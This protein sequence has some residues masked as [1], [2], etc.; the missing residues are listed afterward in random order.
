MSDKCFVDTN[1]LVYAHDRST[2]IKHERAQGLIERLWRDGT[3][4]LSTQVLQEL[5][6]NLRRKVKR[7]LPM[8]E[9]RQIIR[10]YSRWEL[11]SHTAE[12]IIEALALEVRYR[13]S[14]WD[15][16]ILQAAESCGAS[17]LY[18]E[19]LSSGQR[20]GTLLVVNPFAGPPIT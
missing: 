11:V 18:S 7:P 16:L 2:G 14:F 12:S 13:I 1:I 19:D 9:L 17:I 5:C 4:V 15:A 10:D 6:V 8:E 20:F 3:G